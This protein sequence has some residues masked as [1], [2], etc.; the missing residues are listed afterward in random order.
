[1]VRLVRSWWAT[2]LLGGAFIAFVGLLMLLPLLMVVLSAFA[3]TWTMTMFPTAL[4]TRWFEVIHA[5]YVDAILLSL[6]VA[7]TA[8]TA[9][10]CLGTYA[11][12]V[13]RRRKVPG[14]ALWDALLMY[15][16]ALPSVVMGLALLIAFHRPPVVLTG[17]PLIIVLAH[18]LIVFPFVLRTVSAV[19]DGLDPRYEEAAMSLGA[20]ERQA[21]VKIVLPLAAPGIVS[22][23]ILSFCLSIGELGATM[24]VY[25]PSYATMTVSIYTLAERGFYYQSSAMSVILLLVA[26]VCLAIFSRLLARIRSSPWL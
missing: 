9:A 24:M 10:A 26:F 16:I 8:S 3:S 12:Y 5:R 2:A 17:G 13:L 14:A 6:A 1:V 22:G 21:F 19:L 25:P 7:V 11:A 23:F 20:T 15:P 4:T 18:F